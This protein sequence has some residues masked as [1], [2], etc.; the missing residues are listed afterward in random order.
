MKAGNYGQTLNSM[1][2]EGGQA[3][4]VKAIPKHQRTTHE[5]TDTL[6]ALADVLTYMGKHPTERTGCVVVSATNIDGWLA[7]ELAKRY[8]LRLRAAQGLYT[9]E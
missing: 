5:R 1:A 9:F 7:K 8:G 4:R 6:T 2:Y 3:M